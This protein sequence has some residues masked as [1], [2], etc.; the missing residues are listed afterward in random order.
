M[1]ILRHRQ[2]TKFPKLT[3]LTPEV[4]S[5]DHVLNH[6]KTQPQY[7]RDSHRVISSDF[8]SLICKYYLFLQSLIVLA[9]EF[10]AQDCLEFIES[11]QE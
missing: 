11:H 9:Q 10:F 6:Y 7:M 8:S 4:W 5:R 3:L 1:R 2:V